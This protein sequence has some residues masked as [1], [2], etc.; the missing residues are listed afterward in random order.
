[1]RECEEKKQVMANG[2]KKNIFGM[3]ELKFFFGD[4]KT[5]SEKGVLL[6]RKVFQQI[7]KT[8]ITDEIEGPR[9]QVQK[10]KLSYY[11]SGKVFELRCRNKTL[12]SRNQI[13]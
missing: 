4:E 1:M 5:F 9:S 8:H 12:A 11:V 3:K 7:L 13:R 10:N 2:N 6:N